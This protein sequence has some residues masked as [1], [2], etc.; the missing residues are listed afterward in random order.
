GEEGSSLRTP[1]IEIHGHAIT[2]LLAGEFIQPLEQSYQRILTIV[3]I[4][5]VAAP[6]LCFSLRPVAAVAASLAAIAVFIAGSL[7]AFNRGYVVL[8]VPPFVGAAI[9]LGLSE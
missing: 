7:W 3:L 1:G 9:A 2:T 4:A 6:G 5:L 8:V